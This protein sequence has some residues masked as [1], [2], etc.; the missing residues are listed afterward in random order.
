[1]CASLVTLSALARTSHYLHGFAERYLYHTYQ[2]SIIQA[3]SAL[4]RAIHYRRL[5]A[6]Y[7]RHIFVD[8]YTWKEMYQTPLM[9]K[10]SISTAKLTAEIRKLSLPCEKRR[11]ALVSVPGSQE[12]VDLA[13]LVFRSRY[14]LRKLFILCGFPIPETGPSYIYDCPM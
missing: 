11:L 12:A 13:L 5:M 9:S 14:S 10:L 2:A 3:R 4:L 7:I 1:M 8:E 6:C